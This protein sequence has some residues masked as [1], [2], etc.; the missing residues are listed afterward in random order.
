MRRE[1][2]A[3]YGY[4]LPLGLQGQLQQR[5]GQGGPVEQRHGRGGTQET[6]GETWEMG[7]G[8]WMEATPHTPTPTIAQPW[9]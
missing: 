9:A 6:W 3:H 1:P 5:R 7:R 2:G 4:L 8:P